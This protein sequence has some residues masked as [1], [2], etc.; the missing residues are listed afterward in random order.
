MKPKNQETK[1]QRKSKEQKI[2]VANKYRQGRNRGQTDLRSLVQRRVGPAH[3]L[4]RNACNVSGLSILPARHSETPCASTFR[5][6]A[7]GLQLL[8]SKLDAVL[9]PISE[10][11][12]VTIVTDHVFSHYSDGSLSLAASNMGFDSSQKLNFEMRNCS[13]LRLN[14]LFIDCSIIDSFFGLYL[15]WQLLLCDTRESLNHLLK[16]S[17]SWLNCS[18]CSCRQIY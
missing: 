1:L 4:L 15:L 3:Q 2:Q 18:K 13:L 12:E 7:R 6:Q 14:K 9:V 10:G 16:L 17:H 11:T 8:A 5:Q